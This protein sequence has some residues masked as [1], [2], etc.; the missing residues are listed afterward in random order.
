MYIGNQKEE[1]EFDHETNH[2][3]QPSPFWHRTK[4][5]GYFSR[6]DWG[7]GL[8]IIFEYGITVKL[9]LLCFTLYVSKIRK[10]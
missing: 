7:L 4:A 10:W 3:M 6:R 5:Y 1:I 9:Q 8:S 2:A